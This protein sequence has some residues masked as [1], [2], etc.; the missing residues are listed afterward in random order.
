MLKITMIV[1]ALVSISVGIPAVQ[2]QHD[3]QHDGHDHHAI[4]VEHAVHGE[5]ATHGVHNGI[6]LPADATL[7]EWGFDQ[8]LIDELRKLEVRYESQ[9]TDLRAEL[10]SAEEELERLHGTE[11]VRE[12]TMHAAIDRYF[13]A[14]AD[15]LK[16]HATAAVEARDV[17]GEELFRKIFDAHQPHQHQK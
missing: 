11:Q 14:K 17:M 16:L 7:K 13:E 9:A 4:H 10:E 8:D 15:L 3:H 12:T 5:H 1:L 6:H 2:A